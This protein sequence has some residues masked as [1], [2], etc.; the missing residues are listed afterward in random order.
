MQILL[1]N[2]VVAFLTFVASSMPFIASPELI[3]G[4]SYLKVFVAL[5]C[6]LPLV[7]FIIRKILE[8]KSGNI[9]W[10]LTVSLLLIILL[11]LTLIPYDYRGVFGA[12]GRNNGLL[13]ILLYICFTLL[14]EKNHWSKLELKLI[15]NV[16]RK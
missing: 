4:I 12:P 11:I 14:L 5:V 7:P 3:E 9:I 15:E 2:K 13:S 1:S 16:E 6:V 8:I 10:I